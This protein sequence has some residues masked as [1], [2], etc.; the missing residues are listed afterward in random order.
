VVKKYLAS[1]D[2]PALHVGCG[3]S[4]KPGWLNTDRYNADAD[5]YLDARNPFPFADD[6]FALIFTEHMIEHLEIDSIRGFLGELFRVLRPGGTCRITCP[7]LEIYAKA[8]LERDEAFFAEVMQGTE[9]KRQKYP[10]LGWVVR[11]N[12]AAFMTGIVK[13]FHGHRWMYDFETLQACLGEIGFTDIVQQQCGV[14]SNT[15]LAGMDNPERA[16]ESVYVE[17]SKT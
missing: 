17:A 7:N 10:E 3:G 2:E 16:F 11:S 5:T 4:I 8:Y 6:S 9:Y 12:G 1:T 15:R 14:S 13:H